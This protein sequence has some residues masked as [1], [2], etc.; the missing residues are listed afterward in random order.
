MEKIVFNAKVIGNGQC[1]HAVIAP[2]VDDYLNHLTIRS[3]ELTI[4]EYA[5]AVVLT[6]KQYDGTHLM[7]VL[8]ADSYDFDRT[9]GL[10]NGV[11]VRL[12]QRVIT[13]KYMD[14]RNE[15]FCCEQYFC[16][17]SENYVLNLRQDVVDNVMDDNLK[18][19]YVTKST[20][21]NIEDGEYKI[22]SRYDIQA[23]FMDVVR[24]VRAM[25]QRK[26]LNEMYPEHML[27]N[28]ELR[29]IYAKP[30]NVFRNAER[31]KTNALNKPYIA[32]FD[33]KRLDA[34][35]LFNPTVSVEDEIEEMLARPMHT[36]KTMARQTLIEEFER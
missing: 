16:P 11:Y 10:V 2:L 6:S 36:S 35:A 29:V 1:T 25:P 18:Y 33:G 22:P 31:A 12:K 32:A 3:S 30:T 5:N 7:L 24:G 20:R 14:C 28:E 26:P 15:S 23:S 27:A 9:V 4:C 8:V 21:K 19:C 13:P 34:A 17:E